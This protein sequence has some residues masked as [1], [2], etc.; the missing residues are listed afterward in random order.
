[1]QRIGILGGTFDPPH[2]G[3]LVL[4]DCAIESLNLDQLL[5]VPA[6]DPPHKHNETRQTIEHRLA[7]LQLALEPDPRFTLSRIDV[8]RPGPHYAADM[9][10]I[11]KD[12]NPDAELYFVMGGD[13][14]HDLPNWYCPE[15]L[16]ELCRLAV[17]P[18]ATSEIWPEMHEDVLPGTAKTVVMI[19]APLVEL[20]S[21][22]IVER[23]MH[24]KS[25]RYLVPEPVLRYIDSHECYQG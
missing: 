15:A 17:M 19:D 16:I 2:I 11:I 13:S 5:F 24:H 6:G 22:E 14:F 3:H 1:M 18:R 21:T 12:Q 8:D 10:R 7:M 20:S 9:V 23:L 4:A 25:V